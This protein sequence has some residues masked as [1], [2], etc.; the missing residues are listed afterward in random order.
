M[1][2]ETTNQSIDSSVAVAV[3]GASSGKADLSCSLLERAIASVPVDARVIVYPGGRNA[4]LSVADLLDKDLL[5]GRTFLGYADDVPPEGAADCLTLDDSV[6]R[7][8]PT[9]VLLCSRQPAIEARLAMK[10]RDRFP[11]LE[12]VS[13][14]SVLLDALAPAGQSAG[15][16]RSLSDI[17]SVTIIIC[18]SCNLRCSFCYQ[19]DFTQ[20]MAPEVFNEKLSAVYQHVDSISLVGGEVTAYTHAW[21]FVQ[22]LADAYPGV[23]LEM[24]TNGTLFGE[25][26]AD[27]FCRTG[28][29]V[30][31]SLAAPT[32]KTYR[33]VTGRD[34]HAQVL[35]NVRRTVQM[36]NERKASLGVFLGMVVTPQTQHE[37]AAVVDL[38]ADLG[39][40]A[41]RIGV[42]TMSMHKLDRDLIESQVRR[43]VKENLVAVHWDRLC[44]LYPDLIADRTI[45]TPCT[46]AKDR[47][48]IEVNGDVFVCCHS[49][50]CIGS[51]LDNDI[52]TIWR[53]REGYAVERDVSTGQCATC[54]QDCIYRP[55]T[56]RTA[57]PIP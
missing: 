19:T 48:F 20:R 6:A 45:T 3:S 1:T 32:A 33:E 24:T 10:L 54:P 26:W 43:V 52:E 22:T 38:G 27:V 5:A 23:A 12:V 36:R 41:V 28:G 7:W 53:S 21:P 13:A 51:L 9:H 15:R 39:V 11:H 29:S 17:G 40:D 25:R 8:H 14:R 56:V 30:Q 42:D 31:T 49:H 2:P 18:K 16:E 55:A 37:I 47:L 4:R 35:T 34:L 44:M 57:Q 46:A 50:L